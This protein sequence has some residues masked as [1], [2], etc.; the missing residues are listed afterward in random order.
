MTW[1]SALISLAAIIVTGL[2][3][4]FMLVGLQKEAKRD[5]VDALS[6]E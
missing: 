3:M 2:S 4:W 1:Q 6:L 5:A